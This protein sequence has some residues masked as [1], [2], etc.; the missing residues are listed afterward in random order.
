MEKPK[1]TIC[2]P[3]P[4]FGYGDNDTRP[5]SSYLPERQLNAEQILKDKDAAW[6]AAKVKKEEST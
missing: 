6:A 5:G 3:M 1:V 2:P 4:A